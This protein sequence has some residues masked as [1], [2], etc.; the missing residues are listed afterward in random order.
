[1]NII[2]RSKRKSFFDSL[3]TINISQD[4]L[5][6]IE[7]TQGYRE[8]LFELISSAKN[9][10]YITALYLQDDEAGQSV[11][12]ALYEAKQKNP[13]LDVKVFVDFLRA[14]RGLMGQAK[15][16]G[17]VGL[18]RELNKKYE[19]KMK[20]R[21]WNW[22]KRKKRFTLNSSNKIWSERTCHKINT[23]DRIYAIDDPCF[24]F[25]KL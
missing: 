2:L 3:E 7:T 25:Y 11:L 17:N 12:N 14:Q 19:H 18:Y 9:R 4:D 5:S 21:P 6:I 1:M 13:K 22:P 16:I 15:S 23:T 8:K 20:C 10:I 24:L